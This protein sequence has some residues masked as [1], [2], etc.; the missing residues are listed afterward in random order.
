MP[1]YDILDIGRFFRPAPGLPELGP[2]VAASP[3]A[4]RK[5]ARIARRVTLRD[6]MAGAVESIGARFDA[7]Y[8]SLSGLG[9]SNDKGSSA[10]PDTSRT[11]LTVPHL[12]VLYRF[13]AYARRIVDV[14]P[15]EATRKWLRIVDDTSTSDVLAG[16]ESR[17]GVQGR[18]NQAMKWARHAGGSVILIIT[19]ED[20]DP[21]ERSPSERLRRPLDPAR[22][23]RIRNLVLCD[24][25][26]ATPFEYEGDVR[27]ERFGEP[28]LWSINPITSGMIGGGGYASGSIIHHSRVLYFAGREL[29]RRLRQQNSGYD[30]SVL[31]ACWNAIRSIESIDQGA[32]LIAQELKLNVLKIAGLAEL[33]TSDQAVAFATR[34]QQINTSKSLLNLLLLDEKES[35]DTLGTPT[36]GFQYLDANARRALATA[37]EM[38]ETILFGDAPSGLNTD[39]AS[40]RDSWNKVIASYQET[41]IRRHLTYL[42]G[43]IYAQREGPTAGVVPAKWKIEFNSLDEPTA[44]E[45]A[46][47]KKT[48]ADTD[49][50]YIDRGVLTPEHVAASRF[51]DGG[52]TADTLPVEAGADD[53]AAAAEARR[54]AVAA[55][56][57]GTAVIPGDP[58]A[59]ISAVTYN[60][61]QIKE[62]RE[63]VLAVANGE[64][65]RD[66]AIGMLTDLIKIDPAG[67]ERIMGSVGRGFVPVVVG[68]DGAKPVARAADQV[69]PGSAP[70]RAAVE[71]VD[72]AAGDLA[73]DAAV[74]AFADKLTL[75]GVTRCEHGA[76]N[77]CRICGIERMRDF[78]TNA[79]GTPKL[80]ADGAPVWSV[81][82]RPIYVPV[83]KAAAAK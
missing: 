41:R 65:P 25:L 58:S 48:V 12:D 10:M 31:E 20:A 24:R 67:A 47:L 27:S 80:G 60:G 61:A 34:M 71:G 52:W 42:Y 73:T 76:S 79:D 21:A 39:G 8:N 77:R 3:P 56:A 5:P 51:G 16:E 28:R 70:D 7:L 26:E 18:T 50:L 23:V 9:G 38:P 30:D 37:A 4:R 63:L 43:L 45:N 62:A 19:D 75:A 82:W 22:L 40:G 35:F 66:T 54:L 83:D 46:T 11:P 33:Q 6:R 2:T 13:S 69:A 14:V 59:P 57:T 68:T 81:K 72:D 49:A 32:A 15:N 74:E 17:L 55:E 36:E 53:V 44:Q 64:L 78:E 1:W 29:P